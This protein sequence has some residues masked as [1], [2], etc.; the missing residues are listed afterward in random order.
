[1]RWP[2]AVRWPPR[3]AW[4]G[5]LL[6]TGMGPPGPRGHF[7]PWL[8]AAFHGSNALMSIV[9]LV[10]PIIVMKGYGRRRGGISTGVIIAANVLSISMAARSAEAD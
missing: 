4:A 9:F 6:D 8:T 3:L 1:M 2:F 7:T 5:W 10:I